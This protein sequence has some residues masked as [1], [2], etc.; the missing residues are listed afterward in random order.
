MLKGGIMRFF[1]TLIACVMSASLVGCVIPADDVYV[2]D[3]GPHHCGDDIAQ[4]GLQ[5]YRGIVH[6]IS[7]FARCSSR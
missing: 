4:L 2:V 1:P 5:L 7:F 3:G 6:V